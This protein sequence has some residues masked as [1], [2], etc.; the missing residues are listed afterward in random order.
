MSISEQ[1]REYDEEL[2]E[3]QIVP[4]RSVDLI[5]RLDSEFPPRCKLLGESEEEH[6]R[7][8]GIRQLIDELKGLIDEQVNT[9][10]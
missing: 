2:L 5:S 9:A 10:E 4:A 8:A 1:M 7:Y 3:D 6:Q